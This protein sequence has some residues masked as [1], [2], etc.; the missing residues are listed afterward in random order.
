MNATARP[1]LREAD[2]ALFRGLEALV[3][4]GQRR[5]ELSRRASSELLAQM[6]EGIFVKLIVEWALDFHAPHSLR[7]R[8]D[9]A[10]DLFLGG[11]RTRTP[12]RARR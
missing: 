1:E 4:D 6:L 3:A 10:L 12:R 5:R 8:M 2:A 11:V 7:E 9:R